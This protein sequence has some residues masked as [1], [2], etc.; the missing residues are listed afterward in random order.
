MIPL[1]SKEEFCRKV[2]A[3][4]LEK[5]LSYLESVL[6]IQEQN[7]MDYSLVAKFLSQPLREKLEKEAQ[8]LNLIKK[9]KNTLPFV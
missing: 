5:N 3:L 6:S 2:E 1:L 8:D 9:V 4:V 7:Q